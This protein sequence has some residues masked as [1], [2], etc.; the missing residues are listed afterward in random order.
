MEKP[1]GLLAFAQDGRQYFVLLIITDGIITDFESTLGALVEASA[2]PMSVIIVGVGNEDFSAMEALDADG[3]LIRHRGRTATR[4]I[5]QFV[6]LRKFVDPRTGMWDK[7]LLAKA[8][9]AEV[10][11]QVTRWMKT[12]EL[13]PINWN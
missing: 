2:L 13:K 7:S 12:R 3:G 4:D 5:V 11:R 9:L 8:V 6:E 1:E 10:P